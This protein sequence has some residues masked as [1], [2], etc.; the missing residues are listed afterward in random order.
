[1]LRSNGVLYLFSQLTTRRHDLDNFGTKTEAYP[2]G[3]FFDR[4]RSYPVL[5]PNIQSSA[6]GLS[7]PRRR[8]IRHPLFLSFEKQE[9]TD[10]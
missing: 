8:K 10:C 9:I 6:V 3:H 5:Y 7:L 1:M 4:K 2:I